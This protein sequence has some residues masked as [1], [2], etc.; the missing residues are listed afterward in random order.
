MH[1]T[2]IFFSPPSLERV[3]Q[4]SAGPEC[5]KL[6][7]V[8]KDL[9]SMLQAI[10]RLSEQFYGQHFMDMLEDAHL[11]IKKWA[12]SL[13]HFLFCRPP[14]IKLCLFC[15]QRIIVINSFCSLCNIAQ[16][17]AD[18]MLFN[19]DTPMPEILEHDFLEL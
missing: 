1:C 7:A 8:L 14:K 9:T 11:L 12:L 5:E 6:H 4:L 2:C 15:V 16:Y 17:N 10:G 13:N 3:L 19:V 18:N